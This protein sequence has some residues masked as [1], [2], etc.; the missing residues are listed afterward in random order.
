MRS[1]KHLFVNIAR[2]IMHLKNFIKDHIELHKLEK[3]EQ[4]SSQGNSNL[5]SENQDEAFE[6]FIKDCKKDLFDDSE[7]DKIYSEN[8]SKN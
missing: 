6:N 1:I 2:F 4:Q 8:E 5:S 3:N 7:D